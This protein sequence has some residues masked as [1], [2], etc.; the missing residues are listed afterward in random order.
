MFDDRRDEQRGS[1]ATPLVIYKNRSSRAESEGNRRRKSGQVCTRAARGVQGLGQWRPKLLRCSET[2]F[3]PLFSQNHLPLRCFVITVRCPI[4][5]QKSAMDNPRVL[6]RTIGNK[7][8]LRLLGNEIVRIRKPLR[9]QIIA[10]SGKRT[11]GISEQNDGQRYPVSP[12]IRALAP[13]TMVSVFKMFSV[14]FPGTNARS[15]RVLLSRRPCVHR[16]RT[17]CVAVVVR[18]S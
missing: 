13:V 14:V 8:L 4:F 18:T 2:H 7:R 3:R 1:S 17:R 5:R 15:S 9:P 16:N 12:R 11:Q 10:I 6:H